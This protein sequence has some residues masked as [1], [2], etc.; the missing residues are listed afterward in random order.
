[1]E[2]NPRELEAASGLQSIKERQKQLNLDALLK[3]VNLEEPIKSQKLTTTEID[4]LLKIKKLMEAKG[5]DALLNFLK[6][7]EH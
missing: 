1:M 5:Q 2:E 7:G 6:S 3:V 4:E